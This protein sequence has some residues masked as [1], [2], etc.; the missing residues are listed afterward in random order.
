MNRSSSFDRFEFF[1][2][3]KLFLNELLLRIKS[4]IR[5]KRRRNAQF[6]GCI[7]AQEPELW[8]IGKT[9]YE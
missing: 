8:E 4:S 5:E 9:N 3:Y 2:A 1:K 6:L 7:R